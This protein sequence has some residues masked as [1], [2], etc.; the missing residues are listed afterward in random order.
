M[1]MFSLAITC[2]NTSN[3]PWFMDLTFQVHMQYCSLQH[4]TLLLSPVTSTTGYCFC[5]GSILSFFLEL[6]LGISKLKWTGL[7]EFNSDDHYIYYCGQESLRRNGVAII[8]DKRV[9]CSTWMQ[10]QKWQN[11]LSS[12][13]RQTIQYHGN[14]SLRLITCALRFGNLGPWW[15]HSSAIPAPNCLFSTFCCVKQC[16]HIVKILLVVFVR[17][18]LRSI[19]QFWDQ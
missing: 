11:D 19:R 16:T 5:F 18:I 10:S 1:S 8:A 13:L 15:H 4:Q 12:F 17:S 6:F 2:L 14:P 9:K 3:L 7:N